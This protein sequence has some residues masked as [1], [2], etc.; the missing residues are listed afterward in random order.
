MTGSPGTQ[1]SGILTGSLGNEKATWRVE[2]VAGDELDGQ[3]WTSRDRNGDRQRV[4]TTGPGLQEST[5]R[6]VR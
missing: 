2:P 3:E 1:A 4:R 5:E 6:V